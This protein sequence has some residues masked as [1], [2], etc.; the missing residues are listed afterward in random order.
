[1]LTAF[2]IMLRETLEAALIIGIISSF[3]VRTD[4][5]RYLIQVVGGGAAGIAASLLAAFLFNRFSN[6][7]T[8]KNEAL[9]EGITM[10]VGALLITTMIFWMMNQYNITRD[11][12]RKVS[13]RVSGTFGAGIFFLAFISILREGVESVIFLAAFRFTS[14]ENTLFGALLGMVAA[15]VLGYFLFLGS[16]K[17]NVKKVF[18][19]TSILLILFAAGLA[20]HGVHELQ[21]AGVMPVFVEH[22]WDVN[23]LVGQDGSYPLFHENGYIGSILKGLFGYNGNP[24]LLEVTVNGAYIMVVLLSWRLKKRGKRLRYGGLT[25]LE[26]RKGIVTTPS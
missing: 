20:A 12:E 16:L 24:S 6:G 23:P 1:M 17:I 13:K 9:F 19:F 26:D 15:I 3:L 11:I 21:E 25:T 4:Q 8:G 7:F 5:R 10:I 14:S 22:V 18:A 2:V